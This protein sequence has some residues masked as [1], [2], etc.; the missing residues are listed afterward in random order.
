MPF[1]LPDKNQCLVQF[2]C[3]S[4]RLYLPMALKMETTPTSPG[5][6]HKSSPPPPP[7]QPHQSAWTSNPSPHTPQNA[8][9]ATAATTPECPAAPPA[10][11]NR[12]THAPLQ[13][14]AREPTMPEFGFIPGRL[15]RASCFQWRRRLQLRRGLE[16]VDG[17]RLSRGG[18]RR[19]MKERER[20]NRMVGLRLDRLGG[21]S[22][23]SARG[24]N[25]R[26]RV[27]I[28]AVPVRC[29]LRLLAM[30]GHPPPPLMI[31]VRRK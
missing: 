13:M 4:H 20:E 19:K 18:R 31:R 16:L 22:D 9:S 10:A 25:G 21:L 23:S 2:R 7:Q 17:P 1:L 8:T 24:I 12:V 3:H 27:I 6:P 30:K 11:G 29:V 5:H 28:I 26:G 15:R 14:D